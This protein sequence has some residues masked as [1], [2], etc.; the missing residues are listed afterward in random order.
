MEYD[1][2]GF[3]WRL[4]PFIDN[5]YTIDS[6]ETPEQAFS[7]AQEFA[8]LTSVL[9]GVNV[10][11][12]QPTLERFH[13]L[14]WRYEQFDTALI[15]SST[16][17]ITEAKQCIALANRFAFLVDDYKT[18]INTGVLAPRI[19]H[20]D[21]KINN[22]LFDR[23]SQKAV[24]VIDLDTLMP[25]YFIYDIGDMIRT[26]VSPVSEEEKDIDKIEVRKEILEAL[27]AGYLSQMGNTLS[28]KEKTLIP[29]SGMMMTYIM[30][31]RMLTDYLNGDVYYQT[32]YPGQNLVRANNQFRLLE[33]L[34]KKF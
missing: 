1:D 33:L 6:V 4:F 27:I 32:S 5:T 24:C 15:N 10:A 11:E 31:L 9:N 25:G 17:K 3:P 23:T 20:N 29:F 30:A 14:S 2:Q 16:A 13:D 7:A 28:D 34:S 22:I 12:F 18:L 21:T 26:F 19:M 8:R